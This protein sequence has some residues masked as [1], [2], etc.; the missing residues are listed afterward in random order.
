MS[1]KDK[2]PPSDDC[3]VHAG[4]D[5]IEV[6]EVVQQ[7]AVFGELTEGG[8]NYRSVGHAKLLKCFPGVSRSA[9]LTSS[10]TCR[11]VGWAQPA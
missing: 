7:D 10:F 5:N 3:D 2:I 11:L 6:A 4:P 1:E 9:G 8:P